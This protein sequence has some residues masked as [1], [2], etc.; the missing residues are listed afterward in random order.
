MNNMKLQDSKLKKCNAFIDECANF[1][2][3]NPPLESGL[4]KGKA[5]AALFL[6]N[7]GKYCS[8]SK[9]S[10][11]GKE[12]INESC[13]QVQNLDSSFGNGVF[14][15]AWAL[16]YLDRNQF[17]KTNLSKSNKEVE[18]VVSWPT[19]V[20]LQEGVSIGAKRKS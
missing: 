8:V 6:I 19:D 4:F 1:I 7:Y 9:Y 13:N 3:N 10:K 11:K 15:I 2:V 18:T 17:V 20:V 5:G 12:Y 16:S 14:G